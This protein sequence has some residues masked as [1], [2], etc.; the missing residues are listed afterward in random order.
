MDH[1]TRPFKVYTTTPINILDED[2]EGSNDRTNGQEQ[3]GE[4]GVITQLMNIV[5]ILQEI[6]TPKVDEHE[7]SNVKYYVEEP[8]S[9][10][11]AN[12]NGQT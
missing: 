11:V 3:W 12:A 8:R 6:E 9:L 5:V 1:K 4:D 2:S 10:I 7:Q